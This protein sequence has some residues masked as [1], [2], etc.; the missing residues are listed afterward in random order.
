[1]IFERGGS[2]LDIF[3]EFI[4]ASIFSVQI[5]NQQKSLTLINNFG[6]NFLRNCVPAFSNQRQAYIQINVEF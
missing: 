6:N 5:N 3:D 2:R 4:I 1:M